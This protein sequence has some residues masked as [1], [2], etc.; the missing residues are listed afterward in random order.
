M[1]DCIE[2]KIENEI[3]TREKTFRP[4]SPRSSPKISPKID[5]DFE[6]EL[7]QHVEN[8]FEKPFYCIICQKTFPYKHIHTGET[9]IYGNVKKVTR[10]YKEKSGINL[11][12]SILC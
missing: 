12:L 7:G 4:L 10:N 6:M 1:D 2:I 3:H 11:G 5:D 8:K 9:S